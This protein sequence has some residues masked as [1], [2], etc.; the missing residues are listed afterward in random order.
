MLTTSMCAGAG[1]FFTF[2]WVDYLDPLTASTWVLIDG[3]ATLSNDTFAGQVT[4]IKISGTV[5]GESVTVENRITTAN[6]NDCQTLR[7]TMT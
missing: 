2:D 7:I 6:E 4:S 1:E 5:Q 3:T